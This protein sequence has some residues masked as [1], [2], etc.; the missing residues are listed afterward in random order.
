MKTNRIIRLTLLILLMAAA[1]NPAPTDNMQIRIMYDSKEMGFEL[2]RLQFDII[3]QGPGYIDIYGGTDQQDQAEKLGYRTEII[4]EDLNAFYRSRLDPT[5]D[6]G[7][8]RTLSEIY[9]YI[10]TII[11]DHPTLTHKVNI[12][13]SIQFQQMWAIKISD[14]PEYDEDEPEIFYY[15]ATHAREVITPEVLIHYMDYLTD[16]YG[17]DSLVTWLVDE[18]EIWFVLV[19][20]PD[21]YLYNEQ[22][23]PGGGGLWRKNRRLN[24]DM[25]RGVD[26]NRN[27]GYLWGY[28]D[29][30]SSPS[31]PDPTY[32]GT[33]PFSEPE[34]QNMRDFITTHE[35]SITVSYHSKGNLLIWPWGYD[36]VYC[37]DED[38]YAA[39]AD[40]VTAYNNYSPGPIWTLYLVNGSSDDWGYGEQTTKN[41]N[42][43]MTFEVGTAADGWWPELDRIPELVAE[44]LGPNLYLSRIAGNIY[45]LKPPSAPTLILADSVSSDSFNVIWTHNDSANPA[46]LFELVEMQDFQRTTDSAAGFDSWSNN[47]FLLSTNRSSSPPSSFYSRSGDNLNSVMTTATPLAIG[48]GDTLRL[49]AWYDIET[50]WDYAFV[51]ASTDGL[52]FVTLQGNI[53]T[54]YDPYGNNRGHGI[55]GSSL[56]WVDGLFDLSD[57]V[58]ENIYIRFSYVTDGSVINEGF[59][60]D[61]VYPVDGFSVETVISS[62]LTDTSYNFI[63]HDT[64]LFYYKV[65]A[66]DAEQQWGQFSEAHQ[67]WVEYSGVCFDSDNDGFGDPGHPENTCPDDNCPTV[68]NTDQA[69]SDGDGYG[70]ACDNCPQVANLDQEDNDSDGIGN[71]CCCS[72]RGDCNN[73]GTG[74]PDVSDITFIVDYLFRGYSGIIDCPVSCDVDA[75]GSLDVADL[76]GLVD[77]LFSQGLPPVPCQ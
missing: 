36:Y 27:Y 77:Y 23:N 73:S 68:Y 29:N 49:R 25:S 65:R 22:T 41:K 37:P 12:G 3:D 43:A 52:S 17:T 13:L 57:Y 62:V 11:A 35:F 8:Y 55:T 15:A 2:L 50:N 56:G 24:P 34:T 39:I 69:D 63:D 61:D 58:G 60:V 33:G 9:A 1:A 26:L 42:F 71:A 46:E 66:M 30:G 76:T 48:V 47:G 67:T 14:R 38:I 19:V 54:E 7:G 70:D 74:G 4:H 31:P 6:M 32:R 64:G 10:D 45:A 40:S 5:K 53:T 16:N 51:E 21:G 72:V 18:R 44:N 75:N 20:N 28:D 59:Y